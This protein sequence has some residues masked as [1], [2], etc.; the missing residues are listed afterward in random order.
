MRGDRNNLDTN[1]LEKRDVN[2]MTDDDVKVREKMSF[3]FNILYFQLLK[4]ITIL[5]KSEGG[6]LNKELL[7]SDDE[8]ARE[9]PRHMR[10]F[11]LPSRT[12]KPT[13][14]KSKRKGKLRGSSLFCYTHS[15]QLNGRCMIMC[16]STII[17][18]C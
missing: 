8:L 9:L 18:E 15:V 1:L 6:N 4:L 10:T 13:R 7:E 12:I 17:M 11:F 14:F 16:G 3:F 5:K 2:S